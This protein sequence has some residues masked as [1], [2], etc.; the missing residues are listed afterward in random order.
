[1]VVLA[2]VGLFV[3]ARLVQRPANVGNPAEP[4]APCPAKPNCVS[5]LSEHP[6]HAM[7]PIRY[8][9][10]LPDARARLID[11]VRTMDGA[12][13]VIETD[14][15]LYAEFRSARFRFVDDV[16]FRFRDEAKVIH[17]RSGSRLG[18]SDHGVNRRRM[19]LISELFQAG[20]LQ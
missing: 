10:S 19:A 11:I 8:R 3:A 14:S 6:P 12:T 15:Y 9:G 13:I 17:F 16:E 7:P 4:F 1:V 5:S 18:Y 2:T 20:Q